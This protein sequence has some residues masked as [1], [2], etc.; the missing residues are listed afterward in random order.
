[1]LQWRCKMIQKSENIYG[2]TGWHGG[3]YHKLIIYVSGALIALLSS[4]MTWNVWYM[5]QG[6]QEWTK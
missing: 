1:M 4:V 6:I 5:G 3:L 2:E